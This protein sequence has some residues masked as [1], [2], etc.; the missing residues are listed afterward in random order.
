MNGGTV[1]AFLMMT[2]M[3]VV[4]VIHR[5]PSDA[6]GPARVE[7]AVTPDKPT[8]NLP[9]KPAAKLAANLPAKPALT[10]PV[11]IPVPGPLPTVSKP[12]PTGPI[13]EP[14]AIAAPGQRKGVKLLADR[15]ISCTVAGA[16]GTGLVAAL[17]P[18]EIAALILGAALV[19]VSPLLIGATLGT[20]FLTSCAVGAIV[21]PLF[22]K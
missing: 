18:G 10:A 14:T 3:I 7:T 8:A 17:G 4:V 1:L 16:T 20:A 9:A 2:L 13:K 15:G 11:S 5:D 12:D 22:G 21:L 19:P 6:I